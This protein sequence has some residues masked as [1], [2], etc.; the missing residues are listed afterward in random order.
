MDHRTSHFKFRSCEPPHVGGNAR[1]PKGVAHLWRMPVRHIDRCLHR[2]RNNGQAKPYSSEIAR[3]SL[4]GIDHRDA[5][6][7][8]HVCTR[9]EARGGQHPRL[10]GARSIRMKYAASGRAGML[11]CNWLRRIVGIVG[12][13][14]ASPSFAAVLTYDF[15]FEI[16][17]D[18]YRSALSGP[19]FTAGTTGTGSLTF[20]EQTP[21]AG[22]NTFGSYSYLDPSFNLAINVGGVEFVLIDSTIQRPGFYHGAR[23]RFLV[24]SSDSAGASTIDSMNVEGYAPIV[25]LPDED[26]QLVERN[27]SAWFYLQS[28]SDVITTNEL[29][30]SNYDRMIAQNAT[31]TLRMREF[32]GGEVSGVVSQLQLRA[33]TSVPEPTSAALLALG[34]I[35]LRS[36][37]RTKIDVKSLQQR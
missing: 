34:L 9:R 32:S 24:Y 16:T 27:L 31:A 22:S 29:S 20:L 11:G 4:S 5:H 13:L 35:V 30:Q 21:I 25:S 10:S 3:R 15:S 28:T 23:P 6:S 14:V 33:P 12:L 1:C 26:G 7:I 18:R 19:L 36:V 2:Q 8:S 37:R 17:D